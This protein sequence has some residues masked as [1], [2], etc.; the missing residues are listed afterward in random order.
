MTTLERLDEWKRVGIITDEQHATLSM[1]VRNERFSVF[2]ELNALLYAGVLFLVGGI[3]WTLRT[4]FASL[5]DVFILLTLSVSLAGALYYC[6]S[7]PPA[8]S[9][10]EV[11]SPSFIFDYV[12]YFACLLILVELSYIEFRFEWLK[13]AWHNYLLFSSSVFFALAYRFDNRFVLSLALSTLAGWFGLKVSDFNGLSREPLRLSAIG[14]AAAVS[15]AGTFM[16]RHGIKKH[17]LET[18]L[19]I[20]TNVMCIALVSGLSGDATSA[21]LTALFVVSVAAIVLGAR[22]KR[23]AFV[24]YGVVFGYIGFSITV[25][26]NESDSTFV[27]TYLVLT[28]VAV[29]LL[30]LFLARRFGRDA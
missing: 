13:D 20:A 28:G 6:F 4:H 10:G 29:V 17:F 3:G 26:R 25:L 8:F 1:L 15:L 12:L 19:H 23:F 11:E 7:R 16:Y 24:V 30:I 14:Y 18:Y 9:T 22:H 21:Y 27:L 2:L 5:G